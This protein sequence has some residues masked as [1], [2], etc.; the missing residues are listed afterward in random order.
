MTGDRSEAVLPAMIRTPGKF[1][2]LL[3]CWFGFQVVLRTAI[4]PTANLDEA[5]QLMLTQEWTLGYG[6]QPPL[7]TWLQSA[8]FALTGVSIFSLALLKNALL[9]GTYSLTYFAARMAT[10]RHQA[11][12]AA[13][14]LLFFIPQ[15]VWESQR[16][17][18]HSVLAST[19]A[20]ATFLALLRAQRNRG[21]PAYLALG[22]VIGLGA[23]AKYNFALWAAGLLVAALTMAEFRG[24]ILNWRAIPALLLAAAIVAPHGAWAWKNRDQVTRTASKLQM[25]AND[26]GNASAPQTAASALRARARGL[27]KML[28]AVVR[29]IAP[30]GIVLAV[31]VWPARARLLN[32]RAVPASRLLARA[33]AVIGVLLLMGILATGATGFKDRWFQPI[34]I[35]S[36]VALS[37]WSFEVWDRRRMA[38]LLGMAAVV[39]FCVAV[40]LPGKVFLAERTKREERLNFP[41]AELG[42]QL[43]TRIPPNTTLIADS[44]FLAGNLRLGMPEFKVCST[45]WRMPANRPCCLVWDGRERVAPPPGLAAIAVAGEPGVPVSLEAPLR[46]QGSRRYRLGALLCE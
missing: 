32:Q 36:A 28:W 25:H 22:A 9:F 37:A 38:W 8:V 14:L 18:T 27:A 26:G 46:N 40:F 29:F 13:A 19:L 12:V 43:A 33:F 35:C 1:L 7:Y 41:L 34:L 45:V 3:A 20:V 11:G 44:A 30:A 24:A 6:P 16:D 10:G 15:I 2:G 17:L 42:G 5:E 23:L 21:L 39:M 4:S 31:F